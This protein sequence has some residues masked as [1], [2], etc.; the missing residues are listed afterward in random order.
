M[1]AGGSCDGSPVDKQTGE[2]FKKE[3][4]I[5]VLLPRRARVESFTMVFQQTLGEL[6]ADRDLRGNP[7]TILFFLLSRLDFENYIQ[8]KQVEVAEATGLDKSNV[9]KSFKVLKEKRIVVEKEKGFLKL[10]PNLAWR[11]NTR[12]LSHHQA[13]YLK[14]VVNNK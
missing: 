5:T 13:D 12:T 9:S 4:Y 7:S 8:V 11:G 6:A 10:N 3:D 2:V 1:R 14:L